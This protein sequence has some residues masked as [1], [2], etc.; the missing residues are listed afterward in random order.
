MTTIEW[1]Y[2]TEGRTRQFGLVNGVRL[3]TIRSSNAH[4][5]LRET[6]PWGLDHRLPFAP[7]RKIF[8]TPEAAQEYA[9]RHLEAAML[10]LGFVRRVP[11]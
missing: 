1:Q 8:K 4:G 3:Y 9:E 7:N 11:E 6:H 2:S 10:H 5:D